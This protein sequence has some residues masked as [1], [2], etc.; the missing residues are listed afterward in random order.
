MPRYPTNPAQKP[1]GGCVL[2]NV[3]QAAW[4]TIPQ[5]QTAIASIA[6][7]WYYTYSSDPWLRAIYGQALTVPSGVPA[8]TGIEFVS[9]IC[10]ST[11]C[12][13]TEIGWA[14]ANSSVLLGFN[15]PYNA[16]EANM[17]VAQAINLWPQLEATGLRLGSPSTANDPSA[18]AWLHQFLNTKTALGTYPKVDF[19]NVHA[20][21]GIA[22]SANDGAKKIMDNAQVCWNAFGLPIW[23]TEFNVLSTPPTYPTDVQTQALFNAVVPALRGCGFIERYCAWEV[24]PQSL[25]TPNAYVY[26]MTDS[27]GVINAV[28]TTYSNLINA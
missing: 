13:S 17:T 9:M 21:S 1:K 26:P 23:L 11:H 5:M 27:A 28:G 15:E 20:Y 3:A 14:V 12:N 8:P 16:S 18:L 6:P 10:D 25:V 24:L 19:V 22:Q 2:S 7:S 4:P